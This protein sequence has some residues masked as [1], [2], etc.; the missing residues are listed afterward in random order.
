MNIV[1]TMLIALVALCVGVL[2][3]L[4]TA[5]GHDMSN[6]RPHYAQA[7]A[8]RGWTLDN[9]PRGRYVCITPSGQIMNIETIDPYKRN[10]DAP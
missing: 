5:V 8:E 3:L 4:V 9:L 1:E 6:L 10:P 7:C 2:I